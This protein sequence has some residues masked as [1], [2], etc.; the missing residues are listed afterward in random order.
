MQILFKASG[1]ALGIYDQLNYFVA[2]VR[3]AGAG[4]KDEGQDRLHN[5]T[6]HTTLKRACIRMAERAGGVGGFSTLT[7]AVANI[8]KAGAAVV[9]ALIKHLKGAKA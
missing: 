5:M 8:D 4:A 2:E 6:Y 7:E 3:V 9:A 1:H